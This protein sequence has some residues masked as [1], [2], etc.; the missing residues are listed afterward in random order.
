MASPRLQKALRAQEMRK[1][2]RLYKNLLKNEM[3]RKLLHFSTLSAKEREIYIE[4]ES[5]DIV[6]AQEQLARRRKNEHV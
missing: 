6:I 5:N 3:H 4:C 1:Q 2:A